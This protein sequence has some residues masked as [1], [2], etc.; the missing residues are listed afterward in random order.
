MGKSMVSLS[1]NSAPSLVGA[2]RKSRQQL[3]RQHR[4][5]AAPT[6]RKKAAMGLTKKGS[7]MTMENVE[8]SWKMWKNHS[9]IM[10]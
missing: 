6:L 3:L 9:K 8:M 10:V 4:R 2:F 5:G 1:P 7:A